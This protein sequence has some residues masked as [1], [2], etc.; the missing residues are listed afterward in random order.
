MKQPKFEMGQ[1]VYLK[2]CS[3]EYAKSQ[4]IVVG[5]IKKSS[6]EDLGRV[7]E[8]WSYAELGSRGFYPENALIDKV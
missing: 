8:Y 3:P 7:L 2:G 6:W 1:T 5:Q 4:P